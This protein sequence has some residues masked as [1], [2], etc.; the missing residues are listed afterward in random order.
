VRLVIS[1][2]HPGLDDAT[3]ATLPGASWQRCRT[4][5]L[6]NMLTR[7]PKSAGPFVAT[8]VGSI[9]AQPDEPTTHAQHERVLEQLA[10]RFPAAAEM[11]AEAGGPDIL[12]FTTSP[13][14]HWRH[15]C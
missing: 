1:D 15:A 8:I 13:Q 12:A 6:W 2:A 11:L 7:V 4:H 14:P 3:A 9:F 10:D 5:F